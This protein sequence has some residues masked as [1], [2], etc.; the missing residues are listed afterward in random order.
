MRLQE[1]SLRFIYK[2]FVQL[3]KTE[4][5]KQL[6]FTQVKKL[7][8]SDLL[9][10]VSE[11][12]VFDSLIEWI[13]YDSETRRSYIAELFALIRL[14]LIA[15]GTLADKIGR[16]PLVQSNLECRDLLDEARDI[17]LMPER[18]TQITP[19]KITPRCCQSPLGIIYVAGEVTLGRGSILESYDPVVNRWTPGL[20][21][22]N[23]R[24]RA[25]LCANDKIIYAIGGVDGRDRVRTAEMFDT[26]KGEWKPMPQMAM[27]RSALSVAA[28]PDVG[29]FVLGGYSGAVSLN[30]CELFR[31]G[32][33]RWE[34]LPS[35][36]KQRSASGVVSV[37]DRVFAIGGHDGVSI[38][39]SCEFLSASS[40]ME[41][42]GNGSTS[43]GNPHWIELAPLQYKRCRLGAAHIGNKIFAVGGY[44]GS[45]F[46]TSVEYFD[47]EKQRWYESKAL[48]ARR[49]RLGV[50]TSGGLMY[51]MAGCEN[52]TNLGTVE[53][54]DPR[55]ERWSTVAPLSSVSGGC[56]ATTVC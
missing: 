17:H 25:A 5:F 15:P 41:N 24:T 8:G 16:E 55:I 40:L 10:V 28:V 37:G 3:S 18:R 31:F 22:P 39:H 7:F 35:L 12:Q 23:L 32:G 53:C 1:S 46:L 6:D 27:Q 26:L 44:D 50:A 45:Q 49:C 9:E 51:A 52:S 4:E 54:Y 29:V 14:P 47:L 13:R 11:E 30:Q 42:T 36:S 56:S 38:F 33:R 2:N 19:Y 48:L 43:S 34:A 21:L 20:A